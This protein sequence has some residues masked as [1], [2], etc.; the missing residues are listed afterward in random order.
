MSLKLDVKLVG[1][2]GFGAFGRLVAI[3]LHPYFSLIAYDPELSAEVH[4]LDC[5][6]RGS[7]ADVGRCDLVILA[8]PV[9]N[10]AAAIKELRPHLRPG[11]IVVDVGSV[12]MRPVEVMRAEL[13][14]FVEIVGTHPLF[15]P[16]SARDGIAGLK[17]A[18]CPVRGRSVL[19]IG[20]FL[21][22]MLGLTVHIVSPEEHDREAAIVQGITHLVA[23]VLVRMEPLPRRLTTASFDHLIQATEMVRHDAPSVFLAIERENPYA[24]GIRERFFSLAEATRAM[25]DQHD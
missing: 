6:Q 23:K 15:G 13:P 9:A 24:A 11:A 17:I 19:R 8:V 21:R 14:S 25:L 5:V 2:L 1:I 7:I 20:A 4:G 22:C 16:G 18:L 3:H 10:L 12:K